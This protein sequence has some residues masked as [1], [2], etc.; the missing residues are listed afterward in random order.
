MTTVSQSA[1]KEIIDK[2]ECVVKGVVH[3]FKVKW[4]APEP[5]WT[6]GRGDY[7]VAVEVLPENYQSTTVHLLVP[8]LTPRNAVLK[9]LV[10]AVQ[11]SS[12]EGV[13]HGG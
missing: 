2:H 10:D 7:A 9:L 13:T 3:H 1:L 6:A 8:R 12:S 5:R 4:A 11:T